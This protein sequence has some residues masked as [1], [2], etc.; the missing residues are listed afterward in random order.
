MPR[1]YMSCN[2]D[3]K[4]IDLAKEEGII[5]EETNLYDKYFRN[6]GISSTSGSRCDPTHLPYFEGDYLPRDVENTIR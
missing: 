2:C 3:Q 5:L 4:M 6:Y 1:Y